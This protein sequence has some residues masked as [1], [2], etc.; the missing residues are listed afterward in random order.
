M[1]AYLNPGSEA[2][3]EALRSDVYVDKT[4]MIAHLNSVVRTKRKYLSVSRP[5]RFGKTMAADMICAYYSMGTDARRLFENLGL[6]KT[7]PPT[8]PVGKSLA[9][10]AYLGAFD[11]VRITIT[12]FLKRGKTIEECMGR[13]QRIVV[14][15]LMRAYPE[16]D[17]FDTGD[18][19]LC[20]QDVFEASGRPFVVVIDE[21][22]APMRERQEDEEGQRAYLDFLRDWLKDKGFLALAYMTGILPIKKYGVHSAL[23]MFD[24]YSMVSPLQLAEYAGFTESE[25]RE[26]CAHFRMDF[27][28]IK[29]WYDGYEVT[30]IVPLAS[31]RVTDE[32]QRWSLY[33]PLSVATAVTTGRI[34][35][36]WGGT[37]TYEA[38]ARFIRMDYDGLKEKIALLMDGGRIPVGMGTYQNDMATFGRSDDVLALLVHLGYLG[39]DDLEGEAFVPNQEVL[40]VFRT[41]TDEPAWDLAFREYEA[42]KRQPLARGGELRRNGKGRFR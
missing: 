22:D 30:G 27:D 13:M 42:S 9:W 5:R 29:N 6:S 21:W 1:G 4:P 11:V 15:D 17:Y 18:L 32:P 41:S 7:E 38:L 3:A 33:A 20:M 37:E 26:L 36:Y 10:D 12:E 8:R 23:N 35:N 34:G 16:V 31:R 19:A 2:F 40:D 14:R 39:W 25:V 24:E 28:A